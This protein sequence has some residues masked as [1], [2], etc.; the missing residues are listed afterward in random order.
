MN[1]RETHCE[2]NQCEQAMGSV[3]RKRTLLQVMYQLV[4]ELLLSF[5]V[6]EPLVVRQHG[7][8]AAAAHGLLEMR[9][10]HELCI[11]SAYLVL[12]LVSSFSLHGFSCNLTDV[13]PH[14]YILVHY[15]LFKRILKLLLGELWVNDR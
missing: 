2:A 7:L 8:A 6:I 13:F 1:H 11:E 5:E 9:S 14:E 3:K 4:L 15:V 12:G 10:K